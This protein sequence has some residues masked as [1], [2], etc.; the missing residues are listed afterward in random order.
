MSTA[1]YRPIAPIT[2]QRDLF[3]QPVSALC[4]DPVSDTLWAGTNAGNAVAYYTPRG[5]RGVTFRV[6]GNLAVRN[7]LADESSVFASG[8]DSK[9]VGAWSKGGV[10]KWYHRCVAHRLMDEACD[11]LT[12]TKI[13]HVRDGHFEY[14]ELFEDPCHCYFDSRFITPQRDHRQCHPPIIRPF[15]HQPVTFLP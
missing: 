5:M 6:G 11:I 4:F 10:N 8:I 13:C 1:A 2:H 14:A 15:P 7:I 12:L 3:A 9:G